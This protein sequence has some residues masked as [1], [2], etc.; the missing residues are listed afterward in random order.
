MPEGDTIF[1][2]AV[3]LRKVMDG[4]FVVAARGRGVPGAAKLVGRQVSGIE[5]RGKHLLM[6]FEDRSALHSH[7]GMT[8]S[9]H[10]YRLGE[11]W[12]KPERRAG[13]VLELGVDRRSAAE[14]VVVCFSPQ[15]LELLSETALR[16]HVWLSKLGPDILSAAFDISDA[17]QRF[18]TRDTLSLGEALLNQAIV[19][20]VGNVYKSE[21]LF[22]TGRDPFAPVSSLTDEQLAELIR[23]SRDLM[24]RNL[25]SFPRT[26]RFEAGEKQ[27]VYGRKDQPCFK[28]GTP[29]A[30]R[31]QGDLGRSTY[32]CPGCQK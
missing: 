1:R 4:R 17:V 13:V 20:G 29:I 7:M 30:M 28:C 21:A 3:A 12:Q 2:A 6:H 16:R 15:V 19:C 27:W 9:W 24:L 18:R 11:T 14:S 26:T 8:G 10:I 31:R 23:T 22:L 25:Q 5:A 32:W